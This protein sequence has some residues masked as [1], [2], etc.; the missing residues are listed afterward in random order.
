MLMIVIKS[1]NFFYK[2]L[3]HLYIVMKLNKKTIIIE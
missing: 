1:I 2:I 3:F